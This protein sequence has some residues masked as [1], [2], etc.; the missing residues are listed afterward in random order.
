[1][2]IPIILVLAILSGCASTMEKAEPYFDVKVVWQND[3]GSDWMLRSDRPWVR[4]SQW[5]TEMGVGIEWDKGWDCP[6]LQ[7]AQFQS[8]NWTHIGCGKR[9]GGL[10]SEKKAKLFFALDLRHQVDDL[11]DWWLR[12]DHPDMTDKVLEDTD[13]WRYSNAYNNGTKWTGQNPFYHLRLGVEWRRIVKHNGRG[14]F[15]VRCPVLATGRSLTQGYPK[16]SEDGAPDLYWSQ[17][18]CNARFGGK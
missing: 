11:T 18:E 2:R 5:R 17:I 15:R 7:V 14:L 10:P 3:R 4:D 6:Y 12:T 13:I 9:W 8:L 1:M 16:E